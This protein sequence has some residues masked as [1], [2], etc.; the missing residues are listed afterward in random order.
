M[1]P[2]LACIPL[3]GQFLHTKLSAVIHKAVKAALYACSEKMRRAETCRQSAC[4]P[5]IQEMA[6]I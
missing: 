4:T 5:S 6:N 2:Y 1:R 3:Q